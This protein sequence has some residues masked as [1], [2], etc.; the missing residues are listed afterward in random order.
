MS[1]SIEMYLETIQLLQ[2]RLGVVRS[3]DIANE[4]NFSKPTISQ[5]IRRLKEKRLVTIDHEGHIHLTKDG[6]SISTKILER[7][8]VLTDFF[9]DLGIDPTI[10]EE[11]ACRVEHYISDETFEALKTH[12]KTLKPSNR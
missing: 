9:I 6:E 10:A 1:E 3:I 2:E 5:Q 8:H 11:D 7:H 4:M 12:I